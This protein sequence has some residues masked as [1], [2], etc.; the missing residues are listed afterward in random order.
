MG[1]DR[2]GTGPQGLRDRGTTTW[3]CFCQCNASVQ[4]HA[5]A[6]GRGHASSRW[7]TGCVVRGW[8]AWWTEGSRWSS[9]SLELPAVAGWVRCDPRHCRPGWNICPHRV[10]WPPT[11]AVRA[12]LP[13]S[14]TSSQSKEQ[15]SQPRGVTGLRLP[16]RR[17]LRSRP[18]SAPPVHRAL[19]S[20]WHRTAPGRGSTVCQGQARTPAPVTCAGAGRRE[21]PQGGQE[22]DGRCFLSWEPPLLPS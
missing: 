13:P 21:R 20:A 3:L 15:P 16:S 18:S 8:G 9:H 22:A 5:R 6:I 4:E 1:E 19:T 11:G 7:R 12:S 10:P 2:R 14:L 17:H